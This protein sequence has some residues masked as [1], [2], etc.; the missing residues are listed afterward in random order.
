MASEAT[1]YALRISSIVAGIAL[2]VLLV[3][4]GSKADDATARD[5]L[6]ARRE[7]GSDATSASSWPITVSTVA[8]GASTAPAAPGTVAV[9]PDAGAPAPTTGPMPATGAPRP[10]G[11]TSARALSV[12]DIVGVPIDRGATWIAIATVTIIDQTGAPAADVEVSGS[13]TVGPTPASC[14]TDSAGKCSMYQSSLPA[15]VEM[16]T[17]GI[18]APQV[19]SMAVHRKGN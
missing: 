15:E 12:L 4:P 6:T 19:A 1:T 11:T 3:A 16:T 2:F 14:R 9:T 8:S 17:I 13:W 7:A 18:T 10:P 5:Q